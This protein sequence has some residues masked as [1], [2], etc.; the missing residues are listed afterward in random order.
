MTIV[1]LSA[2]LPGGAVDRLRDAGHRVIAGDSPYGLGG[3]GLIDNLR[4]EPSTE[5][6][7][8][9]LSDRVDRCVLD[10]GEHLLVVAN[11][12]VGVDNLD[13]EEMKRRRIVATNTPGVLTDATAD[14]T[15]ALMLDA[16]RNASRG[17]RL[18]RRGAWSGW[19]P[20]LLLGPRV[21]GATLG[22]VGLGRIGQAVARRARGFDMRVLYHQRTRASQELEQV[23]GARYVSLDDLL[24]QSDVVSLHCPLTPQ[25]RGLLNGESLAKMKRGAVLVNAGRGPCVDEAA[26]AELLSSG[27]LFAAALDV[28]EREPEVHP[29]LRGLPNVVLA[30]HL[31][32]ADFAT[33]ERMAEMCADA[34]LAVL[35]GKQ[36]PNRVA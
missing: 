32:S 5:A 13:L 10:A 29:A 31:G 12:A 15:M 23:L 19:S 36:P 14:L 27:H 30:P 11:Y 2:P 17:D 28:Y 16:C 24:G 34:V 18:V 6:M 25:T 21:T 26:L 33:R 9:L 35:A 7:I 8:T 20:M 4:R 3:E 1:L 22:I